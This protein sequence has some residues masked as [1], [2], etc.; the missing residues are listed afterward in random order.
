MIWRLPHPVRGLVAAGLT[1]MAL[2][3]ALSLLVGFGI[4]TP[5]L[6]VMLAAS[7]AVFWLVGTR[8]TGLDQPGS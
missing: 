2:T 4:G 1:F 7:G 5:E 6:A 8:A 3:M